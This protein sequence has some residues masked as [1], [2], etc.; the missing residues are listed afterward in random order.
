MIEKEFDDGQLDEDIDSEDDLD[1][2]CFG[3][4][5]KIESQ[6]ELEIIYYQL[7]R[8]RNSD[9]QEL[10]NVFHTLLLIVSDIIRFETSVLAEEKNYQEI[11]RT[12]A[13]SLEEMGH[14]IIAKEYLLQM[15]R[16]SNQD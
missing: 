16:Q 2:P 12:V 1:S 7:A 15:E 6:E 9:A 11:L 13:Y 3:N 10:G 4:T 8:N 14:D 5:I